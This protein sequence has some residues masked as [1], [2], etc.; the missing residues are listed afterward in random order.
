MNLVA[1]EFVAAQPD[2]D[3]GVLVLSQFA[4]AAYE[5]GEALIVNPFDPDAIADA[6]HV[7]LTMPLGERRERQAA[8]KAKV[9][10]TTAD[11]FCRRFME[12]LARPAR[13]P[14]AA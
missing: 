10:H 9:F 13:I 1:K 8:L 7:G 11:V 6:M 14:V 3:P 4:G 12:A 2:D 5:L